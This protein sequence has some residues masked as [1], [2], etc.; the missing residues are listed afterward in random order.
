[1]AMSMNHRKSETPDNQ[2]PDRPRRHPGR[3]RSSADHDFWP[4][5][6]DPME[7]PAEEKQPVEHERARPKDSGRGGA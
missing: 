4:Q 3:S 6:V 5:E 7:H 2:T 1:M